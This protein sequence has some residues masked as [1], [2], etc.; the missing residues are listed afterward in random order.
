MGC[1]GGL[2]LAIVFAVRAL[3]T[4]SL[5]NMMLPSGEGTSGTKLPLPSTDSSPS[6]TST[7]LVGHPSSESASEILLTPKSSPD[8]PLN[9]HA[10]PQAEP[11]AAPSALKERT[12]SLIEENLRGR[13]GDLGDGQTVDEV[14][15]AVE[16]DFNIAT[17]GEEFSLIKE[18]EKEVQAKTK[19][20]PSPATNSAFNEIKEHEAQTQEG[21]GGGRLFNK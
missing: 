8:L 3:L 15:K 2:S 7:S 16:Q 4:P 19:N 9:P 6:S 11:E 1:A 14:R 5:E 21:R 10:E 12:N 13:K 18:L 17:K 20:D